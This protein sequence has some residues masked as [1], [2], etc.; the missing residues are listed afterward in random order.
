MN[1]H[2]WLFK[3]WQVKVPGAIIFKCW[4]F[5]PS[6]P[7][8][9]KKHVYRAFCKREKIDFDPFL[10]QISKSNT[11][12]IIYSSRRRRWKRFW[13]LICRSKGTIKHKRGKGNGWKY[14]PLVGNRVS[15]IF[16]SSSSRWVDEFSCMTF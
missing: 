3:I 1:F 8:K 9:M 2:V 13:V 16:S 7:F 11:W 14:R 10:G 4:L 12:K 5:C 15:K 6:F